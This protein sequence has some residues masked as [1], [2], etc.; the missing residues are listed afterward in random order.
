MNQ[1]T[2]IVHNNQR[3]LTSAQLAESLGTDSQNISKNFIRNENRYLLGKHFF[4]LEDQAKRDFLNHVQ[5]DDG[6]KNAKTIYLWT[7]KGAWLHAKSL[8]TDS[9]WEVYEM[10]VDDYYT[11][12][13]QS[14]DLSLLSPEMQMFKQIWDGQARIQIDNAKMQQQLSD[15][16]EQSQKALTAVTTIKETIIQRDDDWRKS[17]NTMFNSAVRN[18]DGQDFQALRNETYRILEERAGCRLNIQLTNLKKRLEDSGA[19]KTKIK[20]AS[21]MDIIENDKR[22]KEIY[23]SIVKE[24]SIRSMTI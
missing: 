2:P 17:I 10:L 11:V 14:I 9:A 3:V 22:L 8:N 23:T 20:D 1:L 21:K 4:A 19:T 16:T 24:L 12:K 5:I 7:E 6:L 13:Q 15:V 18:S